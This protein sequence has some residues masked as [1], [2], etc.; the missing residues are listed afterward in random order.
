MV[1]VGSGPTLLLWVIVTVWIVSVYCK[2]A[3]R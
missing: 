1:S 2:V 3:V